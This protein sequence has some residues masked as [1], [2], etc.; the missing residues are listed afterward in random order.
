MP[1]EARLKKL[2]A[3]IICRDDYARQQ[4]I[5]HVMRILMRDS[6]SQQAARAYCLAEMDYGAHDARTMELAHHL[7]EANRA[8]WERH[9]QR[10]GHAS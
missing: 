4:E 1:I 5:V 8:A 7:R 10:S 3:Q 2:E 9:E 6:E